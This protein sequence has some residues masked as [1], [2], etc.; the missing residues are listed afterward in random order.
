MVGLLEYSKGEE[1][2]ANFLAESWIFLSHVEI[3]VHRG[4][5]LSREC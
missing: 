1:A 5:A 2:R 3:S 4:H